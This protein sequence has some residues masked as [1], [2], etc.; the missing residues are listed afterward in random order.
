M[1]VKLDGFNGGDRSAIDLPAA[2]EQLLK[3][4]A[5]TGKP[6]VV[7]LQNGNVLAVN[8]AQEHANALLEADVKNIGSTAGDEVVELYLTQ[9][10]ASNTPIRLL[11]GFTRVHL[12]RP[13]PPMSV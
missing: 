3:A 13:S 4:V 5:D 7:V 11:A 1:P 6:P 2:Q 12:G 10:K 9:Q 8:W